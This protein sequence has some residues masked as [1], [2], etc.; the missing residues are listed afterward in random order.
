MKEYVLYKRSIMLAAIITKQPGQL[1]Y[2]LGIENSN[3]CPGF[4]FFP[5]IKEATWDSLITQL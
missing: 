4:Y 1:F 5:S 3:L 2:T